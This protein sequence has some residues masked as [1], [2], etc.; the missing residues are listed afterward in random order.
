MMVYF[1]FLIPSFDPSKSPLKGRLQ[2][3]VLININ[4]QLPSFGGVGGGQNS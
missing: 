4:A 3:R 2:I 1:N